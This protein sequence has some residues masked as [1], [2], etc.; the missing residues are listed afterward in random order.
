MISDL[1]KSVYS[2]KN[3]L[4]RGLKREKIKA[5]LKTKENQQPLGR[6][7][8]PNI[9]VKLLKWQAVLSKK[10][11][12]S[13]LN[14]RNSQIFINTLASSFKEQIKQQEFE[15]VLE[16]KL[17]LSFRDLENEDDPEMYQKGT[18]KLTVDLR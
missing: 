16:G 5:L 2:C 14:T 15:L 18:T 6:S 8:R 10:D 7:N 1:A 17:K 4:K 9:A 11:L 3:I 13:D 12:E